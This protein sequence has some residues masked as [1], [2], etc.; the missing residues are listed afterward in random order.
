MQATPGESMSR[1]LTSENLANATGGTWLQRPAE[2]AAY[3]GV[4]IDTRDDLTG[5]VFFAIVG[6]NHDGHDFLQAAV[7]AGAKTLVVQREMLDLPPGAAVLLVDDTRLTLGALARGYRETLTSTTVIAITG[8]AGKTTTKSLLDTILSASL[9]GTCARK[10]FNNDIGVPL[11]I[12]SASPID[13]YLLL[14]VGTNAP[15]EIDTLAAIAKPDI[16]VITLIGRSHLAGLGS[17][18]AVA[19]EKASLLNHLQPG[20]RAVVHADSPY[21]SQY[22]P[23][24]CITFGCDGDADLRL[25]DRGMSDGIWWFEINHQRRFALGLPGHHNAVNAMAAVA[26]AHELSL[27]DAA[28]SEALAAARPSDMRFA[29]QQWRGMT[30][31]NDA[32]NANP[33]SMIAALDTFAELTTSAARRVVILGDMLE[34]GDEAVN[35]HMNVGR[36]LARLHQTCP[37]VHVIL[38]GPLAAHIGCALEGNVTHLPTLTQ[39]AVAHIHSILRQG[40]AVLLKGSRGGQLERILTPAASILT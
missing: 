4:G 8:S 39:D 31:Y 26:V 14:E 2:S 23:Q 40:D 32:Y 5:C 19:R 3:V 11:T 30:I 37:F 12:L 15:G 16:A 18:E 38:I 36:H 33:D 6:A 1:F 13:Q 29:P 20:G 34:L 27:D 25:T 21:L 9:T 10:S 22:L 24:G 7:D 17:V 35:L 28:I